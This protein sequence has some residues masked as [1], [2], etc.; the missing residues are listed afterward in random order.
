MYTLN[1]NICIYTYMKDGLM[2]RMKK[3]L[4][5]SKLCI[6]Q[7]EAQRGKNLKNKAGPLSVNIYKN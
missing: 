2:S 3:T 6:F 5:V 1:I 4:K 7:L